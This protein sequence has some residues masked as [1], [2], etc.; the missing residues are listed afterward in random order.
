MPTNQIR[1]FRP[2]VA[3]LRMYSSSLHSSKLQA[4]VY[5]IQ[6]KIDF[7]E[8]MLE[9]K[10]SFQILL[11]HLLRNYAPL[12]CAHAQIFKITGKPKSVS[13][14]Q[15]VAYEKDVERRN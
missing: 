3:V 5:L 14:P 6:V 10:R 2:R 9:L 7:L 15:S 1:A 13:L 12:I 4:G 11:E 8:F